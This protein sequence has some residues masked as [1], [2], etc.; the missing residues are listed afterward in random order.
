MSVFLIAVIFCTVGGVAEWL[1]RQ[2]MAC[3][4]FL[5]WSLRST[6]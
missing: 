5:T 2:S 6:D 3:R 1:W 4:L